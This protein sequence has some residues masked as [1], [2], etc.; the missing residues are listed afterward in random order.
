MKDRRNASLL[1]RFLRARKGAT[2]VEFAFV[3]APFLLLLMG[4]LEL[5]LVFVATTGLEG[6]TSAAARQIRTGEFQQS[7]AAGRDDFRDLVCGRMAILPGSCES[8]LHVDVETFETFNDLSQDLA[9]SGEDFD[10]S[11]TCFQPGA[12]RDIVLVRTYYMW[13]LVSPA[14]TAAFANAGED[15]NKRLLT[16]TEAF[17]N[18]PYN[19]NPRVGA[20][21]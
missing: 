4:F 5:G 19:D 12:A 18:E 8:N 13:P 16:S 1:S 11:N 6:A 7:G 21:C 20:G 14:I 3:A 9:Q 10:P 15:N 2:A 17:R